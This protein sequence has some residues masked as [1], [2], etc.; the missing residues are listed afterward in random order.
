MKSFTLIRTDCLLIAAL[1]TTSAWCQVNVVAQHND[2]RRSGANLQ[3][4]RLTG[5]T[6]TETASS[7][8]SSKAASWRPPWPT[9]KCS[10]PP[11]AIRKTRSAQHDIGNRT[12]QSLRV[13]RR[14]FM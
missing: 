7:S 6:A 2:I 1:A 14:I 13:R 4:K 10:L 11:M 9:E 12:C 8:S 5:A 3:E